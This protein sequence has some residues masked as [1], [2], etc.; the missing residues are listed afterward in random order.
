DSPAIAVDADQAPLLV[1]TAN[2]RRIK[3]DRLVLATGPYGT[4]LIGLDQPIQRRL[5]TIALIEVDGPGGGGDGPGHEL[6][7]LSAREFLHPSP[8][9]PKL[10]EAYWVPPVP[11]PD[12]GTYLKIGG[13]SLPMITATDNDD[14]G[15]WF[16]SGGSAEEAAALF[17]LAC[18]LLPEHRLRLA[19]HKP[20]VV[21]YTGDQQPIIERISDRIVLALAGNGSGATTGDEVGRRAAALA[22]TGD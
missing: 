18:D 1:T 11:Y 12:G 10:E 4:S 9:D 5:R 17:G 15:S 2:G 6:P 21:S 22:L 8:V 3:A 7:S 19:D 20:C 13:N 16:R 14:I